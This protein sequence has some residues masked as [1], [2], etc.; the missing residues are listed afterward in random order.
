MY[1]YQYFVK[2]L[3]DSYSNSLIS[4]FVQCESKE[5]VIQL[6][7]DLYSDKILDYKIEIKENGLWSDFKKDLKRDFQGD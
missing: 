5:K 6:L 2:N 7:V 4:G 3:N 1:C